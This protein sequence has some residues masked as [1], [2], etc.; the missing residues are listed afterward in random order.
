VF[1]LST[2]S[3]TVM[4]H[5]GCESVPQ[6]PHSPV[7]VIQSDVDVREFVIEGGVPLGRASRRGWP[8]F[9]CGME[10]EYVYACTR[11]GIGA[12]LSQRTRETSVLLDITNG[13]SASQSAP[14]SELSVMAHKDGTPVLQRTSRR[15]P[16]GPCVTACA[17]H[18]CFCG[19]S[20]MC[21]SAVHRK[22]VRSRGERVAS[23]F[24]PF[25]PL[26]FAAYLFSQERLA[27]GC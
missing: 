5:A 13:W 25:R 18:S 12:S 23:V 9:S 1:H 10:A 6:L 20:P 15:R 14:W 4:L 11:P 21:S 2:S 16:G 22:Q 3:D 7:D 27:G 17:L 24:R 19:Q 8:G 26:H